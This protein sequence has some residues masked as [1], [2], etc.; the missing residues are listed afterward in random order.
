MNHTRF[1]KEDHLPDW[2]RRDNQVQ[3]GGRVE[4]SVSKKNKG[5]CLAE[6]G[7]FTS[8]YILWW[9]L[10]FAAQLGYSRFLFVTYTCT[11]TEQKVPDKSG[12][13]RYASV[14]GSFHVTHLKPRIW[15][16]FRYGCKTGGPLWSATNFPA[17]VGNSALRLRFHMGRTLRNGTRNPREEFEGKEPTGHANNC[18]LVQ[19]ATNTPENWIFVKQQVGAFYG[20]F[21]DSES[22]LL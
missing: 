5:L 10:I 13:L 22:N 18:I 11:F 3:K 9:G 2:A 12:L 20:Q 19:A 7:L 8:L 14:W 6:I 16:R 1:P 17:S 4:C 15:T 21:G